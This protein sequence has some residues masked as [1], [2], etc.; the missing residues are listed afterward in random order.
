M[1]GC[2]G[3]STLEY[4]VVLAAFM[5]VVSALALM[6]RMAADGRLVSLAVDAASHGAGGGAVS[7]LKDVAVF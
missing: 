5:A 3:Q 4:L 1:T 6:W 2:S 7:L